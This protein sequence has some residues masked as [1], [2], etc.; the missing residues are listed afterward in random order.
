MNIVLKAKDIKND[1]IFFLEP[2]KNIILSNS[3]FIRIIYSNNMITLNGIY[4]SCII[5]NYDKINNYGIYLYI[6]YLENNILEKFSTY[7]SKSYKLRE[8]FNSNFINKNENNINYQSGDNKEQ[9]IL[10]ISGIWDT[11]SVIGLTFKFLKINNS[12]SI[13]R[14]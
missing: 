12:L 5:D 9:Y 6:Q 13:S 10:K 3:K 14:E 2:I 7:K 1:E 11:N 8:Y 4:L